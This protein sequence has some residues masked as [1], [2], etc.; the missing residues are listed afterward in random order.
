MLNQISLFQRQKVI[1]LKKYFS[2]HFFFNIYFR[3]I[4]KIGY[5]QAVGYFTKD[6]KV[7]QSE[8]LFLNLNE[9][10]LKYSPD[11]YADLLVKLKRPKAFQDHQEQIF[12]VENL[13]RIYNIF[14]SNTVEIEVKKSAGEQ[15]AI[16]PTDCRLHKAF[17][18]LGGLQLCLDNL[19]I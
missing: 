5:R 3:S 7:D 17:I 10:Y 11:K 4:R 16:M 6:C 12:Q 1:Q 13:V 19:R 9:F 2:I 8:S 14:S 18:Y 15:L